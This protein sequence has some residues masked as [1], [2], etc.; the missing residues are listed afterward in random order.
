MNI[1]SVS[2]SFIFQ[3]VIRSGVEQWKQAVQPENFQAYANFKGE[4]AFA[5]KVL[6]PLAPKFLLN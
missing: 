3:E 1:A 4:A 5:P 2:S 6:T